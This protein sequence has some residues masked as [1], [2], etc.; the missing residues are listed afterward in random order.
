[1]Q[2]CCTVEKNSTSTQ[3]ATAD[4]SPRQQLR[5]RR[6]APISAAYRP[7]TLLAPN[8]SPAGPLTNL[9]SDVPRTADAAAREAKADAAPSSVPSTPPMVG[10]SAMGTDSA[11]AASR[12]DAKMERWRGSS[13][14]EGRGEAGCRWPGTLLRPPKPALAFSSDRGAIIPA[15]GGWGQRSVRRS[16]SSTTEV[17][18]SPPPSLSP[19]NRFRKEDKLGV[20]TLMLVQ[21]EGEGEPAEGDSPCCSGCGRGHRWLGKGPPLSPDRSTSSIR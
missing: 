14:G 18:P 11:A 3:A 12:L 13:Q 5:R 16:S 2:G 20:S 7:A 15:T 17:P 6:D 8:T 21:A 10:T 9:P 1:M 4:A 19:N